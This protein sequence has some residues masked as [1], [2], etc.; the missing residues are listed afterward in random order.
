M[1]RE[2]ELGNAERCG[3]LDPN[4]AA[5]RDGRT[6]ALLRACWGEAADRGR[7]ELGQ[8]WLALGQPVVEQG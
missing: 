8:R 3:D 2:A 1:Q 5:Q 4:L 6:L 7:G